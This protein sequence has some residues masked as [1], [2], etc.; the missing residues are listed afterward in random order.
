MKIQFLGASGTVTGSCYFLTSQAGKSI[1]IDCGIFQGSLELENRNYNR[2]QCD[3][4]SAQG[5]VLT[6]AHMDH[7]GRIPRLFDQGFERPI[8]MTD[9]TRD[10]AE[11]TLFDSAKINTFE[12]GKTGLYTKDDVERVIRYFRSAE[13]HK[14]FSIGDFAIIMYDAG[15]ILGSTSLEIVDRSASTGIKKIVFSGDIGN[16]PQD[17]IKKTEFLESADAVVMESTYGCKTHPNENATDLLQSEINEIEKVGG[18]LLIPAFSIERSQEI[19]HHIFHLKID[20]KIKDETPIFL[21]GPMSQKVTEVFKLYPD[22]YNSEFKNDFATRNPFFYPN[23]GIIESKE[24]SFKIDEV[25]GPKVI[26]AGS[27]M[28]NG[29]R[30]LYHAAKYLIHPGNRLFIVGYQAEE[31][32]GRQILDGEREVEIDGQHITIR[33]HVGSTEVMS[34]HADQPRLLEWLKHIQG[35]NKVF[36]THGEDDSRQKLA[37]QIKG[38]IGISDVTLPKMNEV[39]DM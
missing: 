11:I 9:P 17:L 28:M 19:V 39:F 31:T 24:D 20:G 12:K 27:G 8:Y 33:A 15:H 13:Y 10:I 22:L 6:H 7:C 18:T 23:L 38:Q 35:V 21:D 30:I 34:S 5:M 14:P 37:E 1:F 32:L 2:F 4:A 16:Y 29:G 36:L 25:V 26:I 3:V